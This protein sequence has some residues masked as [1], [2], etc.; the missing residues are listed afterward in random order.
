MSRLK[1]HYHQEVEARF[2][3]LFEEVVLKKVCPQT[4]PQMDIV[5]RNGKRSSS[6]EDVKFLMAC[7]SSGNSMLYSSELKGAGLYSV[8]NGNTRVS[9][10]RS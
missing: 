5:F 7:D 4:W 10:R 2:D 6:F 1:E 8:I 3:R 9:F